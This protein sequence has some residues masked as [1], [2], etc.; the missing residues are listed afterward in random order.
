MPIILDAFCDQ[1]ICDIPS[2]GFLHCS[3]YQIAVNMF[4]QLQCVTNPCVSVVVEVVI[5]L[6]VTVIFRQTYSRST[7]CYCNTQT[8]NSSTTWYCN[9]QTDRCNTV[10]CFHLPQNKCVFNVQAFL[11]VGSTLMTI[12]CVVIGPACR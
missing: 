10:G 11:L 8:D 2:E 9:N 7:T 4:L 3:F 12:R 6:H 1:S 5:Q